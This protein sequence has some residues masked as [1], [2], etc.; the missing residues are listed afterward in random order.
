[1]TTGGRLVILTGSM[2]HDRGRGVDQPGGA[3]AGGDGELARGDAP[4]VH[5]YGLDK[6]N[7]AAVVAGNDPLADNKHPRRWWEVLI[8]LRGER[9]LSVAGAWARARSTSA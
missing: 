8:V 6:E 7:V 1:M 5:R 9:D 4:R 3:A 2:H